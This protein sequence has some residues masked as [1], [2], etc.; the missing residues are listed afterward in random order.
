MASASTSTSRTLPYY[1]SETWKVTVSQD[2]KEGILDEIPSSWEREL[3][4]LSSSRKTG[5]IKWKDEVAIPQ[6]KTLTQNC[7]CL[8]E[9]QG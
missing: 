8:K 5:G 2:S 4:E 1:S 9:L 7:S 3:V 6:S